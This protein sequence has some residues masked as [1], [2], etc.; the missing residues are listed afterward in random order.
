LS[1]FMIFHLSFV[2]RGFDL[3]LSLVVDFNRK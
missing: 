2:I 1:F 3:P